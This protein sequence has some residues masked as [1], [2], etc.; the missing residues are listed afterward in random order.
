MH[1]D[2]RVVDELEALKAILMD[3]III[4]TDDRGY[5]VGLETEVFPYTALDTEQQFVRVTLDIKLSAGY[6]DEVPG[7]C[8]RNPR[9][10][11]DS[12]LDLMN[13]QIGEKCEE[14]LGQPVIFEIIEVVKENL[15]ASNVPCC[16]CCICLYGFREGDQFT[17]TPC[18]H[19]FHTYCLGEHL[20][21][22]ERI[23]QEEQANLPQWQRTQ[24][25]QAVCA[26]CRAPI[27]YNA[28]D[29]SRAAPPQDV[30]DAPRQ[31]QP[32]AELRRLQQDMAALYLRQK[33]RGGII[34]QHDNAATLLI[35]DGANQN[36]AN[37]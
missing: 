33:Q 28:A 32:T 21:S 7:V 22:S 29:L 19:Y 26:V 16:Q 9:G 34:Q 6:P 14:Y 15:T 11:D 31:L 30:V 8:L 12:T 25:F 2:E 5:A 35:T 18:Y 3:E 27:M 37:R 17:K 23:F 4:K 13:K 20:T 10:L 1:E 24:R 36:A